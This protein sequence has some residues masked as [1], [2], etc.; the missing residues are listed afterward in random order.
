MEVGVAA[1]SRRR[2]WGKTITLFFYF[3][4]NTFQFIFLFFQ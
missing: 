1:A 4:V 3:A 2:T